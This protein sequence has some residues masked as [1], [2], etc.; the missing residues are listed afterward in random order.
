MTSLFFMNCDK[1]GAKEYYKDIRNG[2]KGYII[3]SS[4]VKATIFEIKVE[5]GEAFKESGFCDEALKYL[6]VGDKINKLP[7]TNLIEIND[8]I[9]TPYIY[10]PGYVMKYDFW[11]E[12]WY[13]WIQCNDV[14]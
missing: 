5:S 10:V 1:K 9:I 14:F 13:K 11:P 8:S 12:E 4:G 7:N 2:Y 6:Q 3:D